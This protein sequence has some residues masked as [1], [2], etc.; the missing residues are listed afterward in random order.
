MREKAR[1]IVKSK[2]KKKPEDASHAGVAS[3]I[4]G[5]EQVW[6]VPAMRGDKR[7]TV[8]LNSD[9][10]NCTCAYNKAQKRECPHIR[11]ARTA[12]RHDEHNTEGH[13]EHTSV[14]TEQ[15]DGAPASAQSAAKRVRP[16]YPQKW[17]AYHA[18]QCDEKACFQRLLSDLCRSIVE[19][20]QRMGRPRVA[21]SDV[22]FC[23]VF[24]VYGGLS[25]AR[26]DT[27]VREAH[28]NG[29]INHPLHPNTV[30]K[31]LETEA[32][33]P[34]LREM[35]ERSAVPLQSVETAFAA[36]AT[37]FSIG[38]FVRWF[39]VRYGKEQDNHDWLKL[40]SMIGVKTHIITAVEIGGRFAHD[41]PYFKPLLEQTAMNFSIAEISADK[42]Y[43]SRANLRLVTEYEATP[44][45]AYRDNARGGTNCPVWNKLFHYYSLHTEEF[46]AHYH[47]RSNVESAFSMMKRKFGERLRS[48]TAQARI[49]E[50]LCKV[51]CH[52]ICVVI[53]SIYELEIDPLFGANERVIA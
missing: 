40:H 48:R 5:G 28:A 52:N 3:V 8:N 1:C 31:Y 21:L 44:Y 36:D 29:F 16:T 7:F 12:V 38:S 47:K 18:A 25:G 37:G 49:N 17:S 45:I 30:F 51:L 53:G 13:T 11:A 19:P 9:P 4:K 6:F 15:H 26:T 42:A 23:V 14:E 50:L 33:T 32:L 41:S 39:N 2:D 22:V 34:I 43:S 27:D 24:K 35:I 10:P 46:F 20:Q